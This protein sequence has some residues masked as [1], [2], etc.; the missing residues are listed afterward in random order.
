MPWY[1]ALRQPRRLVQGNFPATRRATAAHRAARVDH[2]G[3]TADR[4]ALRRRPRAGHPAGRPSRHAACCDARG[5]GSSE[6]FT[7][8][9]APVGHGFTAENRAEGHGVLHLRPGRWS[10]SSS[11]T[12]ST[13]T[14]SRRARIDPT[15]FDWLKKVLEPEPAEAGHHRPATTPLET[16]DNPLTAPAAT[17]SR[18]VLGTASWPSCCA[19]ERDRLGQRPHPPA[20]TI[21]AH[22]RDG[23]RAAASGRSTPPRTST[24]PQQ[25]RLHR[26]RRQ[27]GRHA[28]D[29]H[30]DG[31]PRRPADVRRRPRPTRCS[32]P[33]SPASSS[34]NDWQERDGDRRGRAQRPQHRAAAARPD[35]PALRRRSELAQASV[36]ASW[37]QAPSIS[38]PRVSRTVVG[39]PLASSRRTNSR[40]SAGSEAVHFEPGRRVERDQ[41]DVHPAPV[42]VRRAARR[43]AGRR[44]SAWSLMPR[45]MAYSMETRRLVVR[46]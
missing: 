32:S 25:S 21:W 33:R 40:S 16:M 13:R 45:I 44:A 3:S 10:A 28:V 35:V 30:H 6:H 26:G 8:T 20:T 24:G 11:S 18:R 9:G 31:R 23:R 41:V 2:S 46:A 5:S 37:P 42:A 34:A 38:R 22:K 27:P 43:R 12:R 4:S 7:T 36:A 19:T 1:A 29:L 14:A 39:M 15:Q 17:T